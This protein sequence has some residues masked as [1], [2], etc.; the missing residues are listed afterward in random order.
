MGLALGLGVAFRLISSWTVVAGLGVGGVDALEVLED[1]AKSRATDRVRRKKPPAGA[2][3]AASL[4]AAKKGEPKAKKQAAD[5]DH[6]GYQS[7]FWDSATGACGFWRP[8]KPI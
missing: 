7:L 5:A 4:A 6:P 8:L 1:L 2:A 3:P